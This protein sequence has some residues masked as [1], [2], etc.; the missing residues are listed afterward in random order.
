MAEDDSNNNTLVNDDDTATQTSQYSR[1]KKIQHHCMKFVEESSMGILKYVF[2]GKS[3]FRSIS[4]G[5]ILIGCIIACVVNV[6][7]SFQRFAERPTT[8]T[9][10]IESTPEGL[11]FP[12]VS[13]CNLNL[14]RNVSDFLSNHTYLLLYYLFN[15]DQTFS[16]RYTTSYIIDQCRSVFV[17]QLDVSTRL[18]EIWNYILQE[19][20]KHNFI[21]YCG[22]NS[23]GASETIDCKDDI[24]PVL[25]TTGL[26]YTFNG[27]KNGKVA[28]KY[29]QYIGA[30]YGLKI[31]LD[32]AQENSPSTVGNSGVK[33]V[34]HE[35]DDVPRPTLYGIGVPPGRNALIGIK[36][37]VDIDET[38]EGRCVSGPDHQFQF[39][40]NVTYSQFACLTDN[41]LELTAEHCGC[42]IYTDVYPSSGPYVNIRN[43]TFNDSCCLI[44]YYSKF[45]EAGIGCFLPCSFTNYETDKSYIG[46]PTGPYLEELADEL[47]KSTDV[48]QNNF[49][50]FQ[51]FVQDIEVTT[52][53][54]QYSFGWNAL[55]ADIGGQMG[56]FLGIGIITF[57]EIFVLILD[58]IKDLT[59][60]K[61]VRE[62]IEQVETE[63]DLHFTAESESE[64]NDDEKTDDV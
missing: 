7:I 42:V 11:A 54:T 47:N 52:S 39:L 19:E 53:V 44:D 16:K 20:K 58:I 31:I 9:I 35:R 43:C 15:P 36:K 18:V 21:Y 30:R 51:V 34:V 48:V 28:D 1:W 63:M 17:S 60:P 57:L 49:L 14:K 6:S 27:L 32:I 45:N 55:L 23:G 62:K 50:A 64:G 24:V 46:F 4:W 26:C 38:D 37:K 41:L 13:F 12:A 25:T 56:L 22:F 40:S 5:I 61:K 3:K 29:V 8:T 59:F 33:V 10:T 2:T